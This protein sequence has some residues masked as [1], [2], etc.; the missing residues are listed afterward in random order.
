MACPDL[1]LLGDEV[2]LDP[3]AALA[4][5]DA[6][7]TQ[8]VTVVAAVELR[9]DVVKR[10]LGVEL[11]RFLAPGGEHVVGVVM[12]VMALARGI[13]AL[14][15]VVM[16]VMVLVV[17]VVMLVMMLMLV[18]VIILVVV[19]MMLVLMV[20]LVMLIVLVVMMVVL[21]LVLGLLKL[22]LAAHL[23][24]QLV[25]QRHL[26]DGGE[27]GLAV[28][29]VPRSRQNGGVGVLLCLLYTSDAADE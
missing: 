25:A 4:V 27:D 1:M 24:E 5:H 22:V 18:V 20:V 13:V 26:L 6:L 19:V 8:D 3:L 21:M 29:L 17:V 12:M 11:G 28:Q 23:L 16:M 15:A 9:E 2:E 14:L 10:C 7:R